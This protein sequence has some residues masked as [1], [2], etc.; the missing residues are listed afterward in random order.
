[1]TIDTAKQKIGILENVRMESGY[2]TGVDH[3]V[4]DHDF[5]HLKK[6]RNADTDTKGKMVVETFTAVYVIKNFINPEEQKKVVNFLHDY[7]TPCA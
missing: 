6:I 1:M 7:I 4:T 5:I 3:G 2:V